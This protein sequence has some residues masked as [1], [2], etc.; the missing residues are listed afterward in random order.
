MKGVHPNGNKRACCRE[1][2]CGEESCAREGML[3]DR[4]ARVGHRE[5]SKSSGPFECITPNACKSAVSLEGERDEVSASVKGVR[6]NQ[7]YRI[8]Q[9]E[10]R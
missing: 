6:V 9:F 1:G 4:C 5:G 3:S 8:R 2:D 10:G 7:S